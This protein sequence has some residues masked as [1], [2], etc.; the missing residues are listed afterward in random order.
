MKTTLSKVWIFIA[1]MLPIIGS[2]EPRY[3]LLV[4]SPSQIPASVPTNM[5]VCRMDAFRADR[6]ANLYLSIS[7]NKHMPHLPALCDVE[8][9][10]SVVVTGTV[11]QAEAELVAQ[12][13]ATESNA[14]AQA[15]AEAG[16]SYVATIVN[17]DA[18]LT[19]C[20]TVGDVVAYLRTLR[21]ALETKD[22]AAAKQKLKAEKSN[23]RK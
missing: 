15:N 3:W 20:K 17:G 1:A 22:A 14:I 5:A 16:T 12:I 21:S 13:A 7:G 18:E 6:N 19:K 23:G 11:A 2:A 9:E 4:D 10:A 8:N